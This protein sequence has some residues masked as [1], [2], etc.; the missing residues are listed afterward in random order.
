MKSGQVI[1]HKG[2]ALWGLR[3]LI[4]VT[5]VTIGFWLFGQRTETVF[6]GS[7]VQPVRGYLYVVPLKTKN[8]F[9]EM[10]NDSNSDPADS[11]ARLYERHAELGPAH[12]LHEDIAT[13]GRGRFSHW[14]DK[15]Y[16]SAS[17]N[18]DPRTNGR[19]YRLEYRLYLRSSIP[20]FLALLSAIGFVVLG[21][22]RLE[23]DPLLGRSVRS[24]K[25]LGGWLPFWFIG[26]LGVIAALIALLMLAATF[27][28][29]MLGHADPVTEIFQW[30]PDFRAL[31]YIEPYFPYLILTGALLGSVNT[32]VA[33]IRST[34][35]QS[36]VQ[37]EVNV[38]RTLCYVGLPL[39]MGALFLI[40]ASEKSGAALQVTPN[41][42]V[43]S[44]FPFGDDWGHWN[45]PMQQAITG[46]WVS[47]CDRR[48]LATGLR[49]VISFIGSYEYN[50]A[51]LVQAACIAV[52]LYIALV[53]VAIWAGGWSAMAFIAIALI[54]IRDFAPTT[55]TA[56]LGFFLGSLALAAFALSLFRKSIVLNTI[57]VLLLTFA[58]FVRMGSMFSI[59]TVVVWSVWRF[60]ESG[61]RMLVAGGAAVMAVLIVLAASQTVAQLYGAGRNEL[62]SNFS[63]SLVGLSLGGN[64]K[65][66][67]R[68]YSQQISGHSEKEVASILY[69][70]AIQ[71]IINNPTVFLNRLIEGEVYFWQNV[72]G[73]LLYGYIPTLSA[74]DGFARVLIPMTRIILL[75]GVGLMLWYRLPD[76]DDV[77]FMALF[78]ISVAS[79][80]PF[81]MF[82]EG[83]RALM[84]T[85]PFCA[86]I[87]A[88]ALK[89]PQVDMPQKALGAAFCPLRLVLLSCVPILLIAV[90]AGPWLF[91]SLQYRYRELLRQVPASGPAALNINTDFGGAGFVVVADGTPRPRNVSAMSEL[92]FKAMLNSSGID[93]R[94][95]KVVGQHVLPRPPYSV[96]ATT[97]IDLA[98]YGRTSFIFFGPP[99]LVE[100]R[101]LYKVSYA[102]VPNP[103]KRGIT[104]FY[105]IKQAIGLQQAIPRLGMP[106][107]RTTDQ[108]P[109]PAP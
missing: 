96:I 38:A 56:P 81:I 65:L 1:R 43:G 72:F 73:K 32:W 95:H 77:L 57:G 18:S 31:G 45:C 58:L 59:P 26:G 97:N 50:L 30:S 21:A 46:Q 83:W 25:Y 10:A 87:F 78:V 76:R 90:T 61:R 48:P 35:G 4:V 108:G 9:L 55:F 37:L 62:G 51:Q 7:A 24:L 98:S 11:R 15:L 27:A 16:F 6:E 93:G 94:Y 91:H 100:D 63:Y 106:E 53:A 79:S 13:L 19:S 89:S 36:H 103:L 104:S 3:L 44:Y 101:G 34:A 42:L 70:K 14:Q 85:T 47:W 20:A 67:E 12:S 80:V 52:G 102:P 22:W 66:A 107:G 105:Q 40:L 69:K 75:A 23:V 86:A 99:Q 82:D 92:A 60:R 71:N 64:W 88:F 2:R 68:T 29:L 8:P 28:G 74:H 84:A 33:R 49:S 5:L 109:H 41:I 39:S 54:G 17:D